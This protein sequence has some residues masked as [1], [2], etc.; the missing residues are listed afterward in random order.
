MKYLLILFTLLF[1]SCDP[2]EHRYS[3]YGIINNLRIDDDGQY[4]FDTDYSTYHD[5]P[6]R[7]III[8][9]DNIN[10][11]ILYI[12]EMRC[13]PGKTCET[14]GDTVWVSAERYVGIP[15]K[16]ILPTNYQIKTFND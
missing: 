6:S 11:P 8:K 5:V 1:M 13:P 16:I 3:F 15:Y 7:E 14:Y 4:H 2:P 10:K 9:R 12:K